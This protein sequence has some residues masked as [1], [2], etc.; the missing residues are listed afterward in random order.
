MANLIRIRRWL[1]LG[2]ILSVPAVQAQQTN[3]AKKELREQPVAPYPAILLSTNANESELEIPQAPTGEVQLAANNLPLS[4]V[5]EQT[6][7]PKP[8]VRNFLVPSINVMS[9]LG[10]SSS[11]SGYGLTTFSYLLGALDLNHVS[12]RSELLVHYAGGAVLSSYLNSAVQDLEFSYNYK[13]QRW[14]L[15]VGEQASFLS[16]SPFGFGG[17]G[18]LQFLTGGSQ[19]ALFLNGSLSPNQTIPTIIVPRVSNTLVSQIEYKLGPRSSWTA[20]GSFGM[21]NF[22]GADFINS[23]E[24]QFQTGYNYLL[25]PQSTIAVMYRF[26]AFRFTNLPQGIQDHVVEL[27]YGRYVTGRLSFQLAAGPSMEILR[28][29]VTGNENQLSWAMD[30]FLNYQLDR[31]TLLLSYHRLVTAGGGVLV[32]AQTSQLEATIERKL[33][34]RWQSSISL[35]YA[36]NQTLGLATTRLD[37]GPFNSWYAAVQFSH[38]LRPESAFFVSYGARLQAKNAAGCSTQNC[39]SGFISHQVSAGFNFGLRPVLFK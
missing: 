21:L 24:G 10:I 32:G 18:G 12:D 30:G 4:G 36:T 37:N 9:Q 39:G 31:T 20:S 29:A 34:S 7:G 38:Q 26:D 13:W 27:G 28:G 5:Q 11:A 23:T 33:K 35:G 8:G 16:E 15:L 19:I 14:S 6:L 17:V 2:M 22:L 25:S 3:P 1:L